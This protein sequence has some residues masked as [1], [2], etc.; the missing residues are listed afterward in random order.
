MILQGLRDVMLR[1]LLTRDE[2]YA[3]REGQ[4]ELESCGSTV[5][6]DVLIELLE[7]IE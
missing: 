6:S 4:Y 7:G 1:L 3:I 5:E 2:I